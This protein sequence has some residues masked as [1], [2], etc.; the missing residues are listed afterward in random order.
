[1]RSVWV[2]LA[3]LAAPAYGDVAA[4]NFEIQDNALKVP[5]PVVF[6]TGSDKL[7]PE[8]DAVLAH[9]KAYL[10]AKSHITLLRI[11]VHTDSQGAGAYNQA[12]SGKRALA[13]AKALVAR[14]IDCKRLIAVGFGD[15]KP[16]APN[17]TPEG[18]AQNRRTVFVNAALR[19]RAIGG[20]PVD[21]GGKLAGDVCAP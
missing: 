5:S 14:G 4:P 21:G 8:S 19:G 10:D 6:E 9:A 11:E 2:T 17:T 1:M 12:L 13:V 3:L 16:I 7:K 20:M 18:R 15:S